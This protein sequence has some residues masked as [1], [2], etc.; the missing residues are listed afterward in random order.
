MICLKNC[1]EG[2][3]NKQDI[4]FLLIFHYKDKTF[5]DL[6]DNI[7]LWSC[8]QR[9]KK[10]ETVCQKPVSQKEEKKMILTQHKQYSMV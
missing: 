4:W 1:Q 5:K 9:I 10:R 2:I 7:I 6:Q 8:Q 3:K